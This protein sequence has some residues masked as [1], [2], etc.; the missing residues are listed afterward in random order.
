MKNIHCFILCGFVAVSLAGC[1]KTAEELSAESEHK[2][3]IST[4]ENYQSTYRHIL[5]QAKNCFA[6]PVS[7]TVSNKVEGQLFGELGF[8]EISY[9]M[10]NLADMHFAYV[11]VEQDGTGA[12]V[13]ISTGSQPAWANEQLLN[14][15]EGW[16][17]GGS[18]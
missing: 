10:D 11:K 2:S 9:Y 18:C 15:I 17:K 7:L 12:Q 6:G 14:Q 16:V 4:V 5:T 1:V 8:G 3:I 13:S